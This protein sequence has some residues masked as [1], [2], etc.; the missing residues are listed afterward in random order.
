MIIILYP[1][2][3]LV[4]G[5]IHSMTDGGPIFNSRMNKTMTVNDNSL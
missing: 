4:K 1:S 2:T 5:Y 3:L